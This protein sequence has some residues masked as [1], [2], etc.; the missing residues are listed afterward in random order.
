MQPSI[1]RYII[2]NYSGENHEYW[3]IAHSDKEALLL[4]IRQLEK[5]LGKVPGAL[6]KYY[7]SGKG[8]WEVH[9]C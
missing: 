7:L 6:R 4:A 2:L 8:F 9:L 1:K 5:D 3:R